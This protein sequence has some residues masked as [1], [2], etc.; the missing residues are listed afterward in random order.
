MT[1]VPPRSHFGAREPTWLRRLAALAATWLAVSLPALVAGLGIDRPIEP[2]EVAHL[3]AALADPDGSE[4]GPVHVWFALFLDPGLALEAPAEAFADSIARARLGI[5]L[6]LLAAS[7]LY[8]LAIAQA[9]GRGLGFV[10]CLALACAPPLRSGGAMVRPEV[11]GLFFA[12]LALLVLIGLP[13]QLRLARQGVGRA[14]RIAVVLSAIVAG[15]CYALSVSAAPSQ[16]AVFGVPVCCAALSGAR[17]TLGFSRVVRRTRFGLLP[18]RS[19]RGRFWPWVLAATTTLLASVA[20]VPELSPEASA[21]QDLLPDAGVGF[22][23]VLGLALA[24]LFAWVPGL[25]SQLNSMGRVGA[26][27]VL[28]VHVLVVLTGDVFG[29][30]GRDRIVAAPS[31][32]LLLALGASLLLYLAGRFWMRSRTLDRLAQRVRVG[33]GSSGRR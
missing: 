33:D 3:R 30:A 6:A 26:P 8:F 29:P 9:L 12:Q 10:A 5:V 17:A 27:A 1:A 15:S 2:S 21:G 23:L 31:L 18:F 7:W 4:G 20:W 13:L 32:G 25:A 24:G 16:A 11:L 14:M 19:F 28:F 22:V